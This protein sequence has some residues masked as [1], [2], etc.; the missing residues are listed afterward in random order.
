MY[1]IVCGILLISVIGC[2]AQTDD[3]LLKSVK[4]AGLKAIPVDKVQLHKLIDPKKVI[5]PERVELGKQLFYDTRLSKDQTVSCA[6]CHDLTKGGADGLAVAIGIK[7]QKNPHHLNSPTVYNAALFK[8][9]FWDGRSLDLEDQ[10]M[11]PMLAPFEMGMTAKLA[12]ERINAVPAYVKAFKKAYGKDVKITFKKIAST[13]AIFERTLV[14]PSRFD[15]YLNGQ[16]DALSE[17]EKKGLYTFMDR[18]CI[19]C[20]TGVAI[21]GSMQPFAIADEFKFKDIG[22]FKGDK[23]GL[24][25][26]PSL[27]NVTLNSPY[28]HNGTV[29]GLK[30]AIKE[31]SR[32]QLSVTGIEDSEIDDLITFFKSLEGR[33]PDITLPNIPK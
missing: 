21:G 18:G 32:I 20:H 15:D 27:R 5:T 3:R 23:N 30:D 16:K 13:I 25:K 1:K 17:A 2:A 14:T 26:V 31:M 8:K 4:R 28:F 9:Q 7:G 22:D 33:K 6:S 12:E 19:N 10:A 29:V 24:V 11:G